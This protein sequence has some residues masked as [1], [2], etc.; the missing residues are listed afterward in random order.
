MEDDM[1]AGFLRNFSPRDEDRLVTLVTLV[2]KYLRAEHEWKKFNNCKY[3]NVE[4]DDFSFTKQFSRGPGPSIR[5][6]GNYCPTN[7]GFRFSTLVG[8]KIFQVMKLTDLQFWNDDQTIN[9]WEETGILMRSFE[10]YSIGQDSVLSPKTLP[11][12][13]FFKL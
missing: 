7:Q 10:S 5:C 1:F 2:L 3:V 8:I 11:N 13:K 6:D 4:I 12:G 9:P